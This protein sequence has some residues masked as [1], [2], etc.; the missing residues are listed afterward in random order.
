MRRR[1]RSSANNSDSSTIKLILLII[2]LVVG[3]PAII[4]VLVVCLVF[5]VTF[6]VVKKTVEVG[7]EFVQEVAKHQDE[8]QRAQRE[9]LDKAKKELKDVPNLPPLRKIP[10]TNMS[11]LIGLLDPQKDT[12]DNRKWEIINKELVCKEG[13]FVPRIQIPYIPPAEYDFIVTFSQPGLRNGISMIMPNPNGGSF[14]FFLGN[15]TVRHY[16]SRQL[17]CRLESPSAIAEGGHLCPPLF[18]NTPKHKNC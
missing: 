1:E 5:T 10:G 18:S 16:C 3:I 6:F 9:A 2:G 15:S 14:Y 8:I 17:A 4:A 12:V 7:N 13:N 11:D